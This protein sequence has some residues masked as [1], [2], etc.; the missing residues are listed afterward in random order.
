VIADLG[1]MAY[2]DIASEVADLLLRLEGMQW[3]ACIGVYDDVLILSVRTR[4]KRGGAGQLVE[5]V[6]DG[7]GSAGGHGMAAGGQIVLD[8]ADAPAMTQ[9][10]IG[11]ILTYLQQSP[12]AGVPLVP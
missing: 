5:V 12:D 7:N 10:I 3:S 1:T 4:R 6:V 9:T 11:R 2:P 8:N